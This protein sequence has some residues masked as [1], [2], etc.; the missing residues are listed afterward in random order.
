MF[1]IFA[2]YK[3]SSKNHFRTNSEIEFNLLGETWY[4]NVYSSL[5]RCCWKNAMNNGFAPICYLVQTPTGSY[6]AL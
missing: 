2:K 5:R 3:L 6:R 1:K 4:N